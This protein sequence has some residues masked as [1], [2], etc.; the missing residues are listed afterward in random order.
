M[1]KLTRRTSV[2]RFRYRYVSGVTVSSSVQDLRDPEAVMPM[3]PATVAL[4]SRIARRTSA[5]HICGRQTAFSFIGDT[6]RVILVVARTR[7]T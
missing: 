5:V 4:V 3:V 2:G 7:S 6:Y 1:T